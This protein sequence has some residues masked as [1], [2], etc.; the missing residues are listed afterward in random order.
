MP[1]NVQRSLFTFSNAKPKV[2][3]H[4]KVKSMT[5]RVFQ[6]VC[7]GIGLLCVLSFTYVAIGVGVFHQDTAPE[8]MPDEI[9]LHLELEGEVKER[10][11]RESLFD[12]FAP[13]NPTLRQMIT[14]LDYAA[15]DP[16]VQGFYLRL[17]DA[18]LSLTQAQALRA[19]VQRFKAAG[20]WTKLYT[21]SFGSGMAPY[22]LAAGFDERWMQPLGVVLIEGLRLDVPFLR[23]VLDRLGIL[24]QFFQRE[25]YKTAYE[26]I[27]DTQMSAANRESLQDVVGALSADILASLSA[28]LGLDTASVQ[29]LIDQGLF[30]ATEAHQAGLITQVGYVD[31]LIEAMEQGSITGND[32]IFVSM[33]RYAGDVARGLKMK[34]FDKRPRVALVYVDGTIMQGD[35]RPRDGI[36]QARQIAPAIMDAAEDPA[37]EALVLR[38]DSPG[39]DPLASEAILR[40]VQ[41]VKAAGKKVIVS[42][43]S[44]A[45]SGGYWVA[46]GA[47][48]IFA[49]PATL[50]GSIGVVG[51][52]FSL[53]GAL[54]SL[55]VAMDSSVQWGENAGLYSPASA[56]T[57][58]QRGRINALM[59][60]IYDAFIARVADG[61]GMSPEAADD[62]A[63]GRVWPGAMAVEK[64]LVDELG[65]L[66]A[67]LDYAATQLGA[68]DAY[69]LAVITL[70]KMPSTL[71]LVLE[72]LSERGLVMLKGLALQGEIASA[73]QPFWQDVQLMGAR[74]V[75]AYSPLKQ[76][77]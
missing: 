7:F 76:I 27:T 64:G 58:A 21:G 40:A 11:S 51:G 75:M 74:P 73:L 1:R 15:E 31:D 20:K 61:R 50:T 34:A 65:D 59:D 33:G 10:R 63:R 8:P 19:A 17:R 44:M 69:D 38:I 14:T 32:S 22:V 67:A 25:E 9:V 60:S 48:T 56:F 37:I 24:P 71:D 3:W 66:R 36:A 28:D 30:T 6:R 70:P 77:H 53:G 35:D 72:L 26:N 4:R 16:R 45:A 46:S 55:G 43:G 5:W 2:P 49:Q 13:V 18:R 41:T 29:A 57:P 47:D 62:V 68:E 52:K 12:P 23:P 54:S 39:G 42:M